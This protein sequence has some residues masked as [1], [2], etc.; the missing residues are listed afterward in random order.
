MTHKLKSVKQRELITKSPQKESQRRES[1]RTVRPGASVVFKKS[2][3]FRFGKSRVLHTA[4]LMDISTEGLRA[5]YIAEDK[6]SSPF[7][8]ISITAA[9]NKVTIHDIYCK[10]M[11]DFQVNYTNTG[12]RARVCGVK[13]SRLTGSQKRKL[14]RFIREH[15]VREEESSQW[16]VQ[17]D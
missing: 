13:F 7:D 9:D 3:R 11:S 16:H 2:P 15:T 17:F 5:R 4:E 1:R 6:W 10:I 14:E 12:K 8:H